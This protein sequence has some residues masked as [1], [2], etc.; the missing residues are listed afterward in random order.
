MLGVIVMYLISFPGSL[1]ISSLS[2]AVWAGQA[3]WCLTTT[4][5]LRAGTAKAATTGVPPSSWQTSPGTTRRYQPT[6]RERGY[7]CPLFM[8]KSAAWKAISLMRYSRDRENLVHL[9]NN[10]LIVMDIVRQETLNSARIT[11]SE[12][13][14][15]LLLLS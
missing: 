9:V 13:L 3:G 11:L 10:S 4:R 8:V 14:L 12:T 6:V 2:P 1:A 7:L 5:G 15:V